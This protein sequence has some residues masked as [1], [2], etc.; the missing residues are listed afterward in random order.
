MKKSIMGAMTAVALFIGTNLWAQNHAQ[1]H[2]PHHQAPS[3]EQMAQ[4]MTERMTEELKLSPEQSK[5][6]YELNYSRIQQHQAEK[7]AQFE[8]MQAARAN[9]DAQMQQI[10][11][12]EQYAEWQRIKSERKE[13]RG[14]ACDGEFDG[15]RCCKPSTKSSE[16]CNDS[17]SDNA[18]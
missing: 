5:Q 10:L 6:L 16:C 11:T 14:K 7:K 4:R 8:K 2:N 1:H 18:N 13:H 12:P 17:Q 9:A 15:K 3:A